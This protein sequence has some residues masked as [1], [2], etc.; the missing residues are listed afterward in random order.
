MKKLGSIFNK[1][2]KDAGF[3]LALDIGTEFVKSL[4]F[5][6]DEENQKGIVVGVGKA[7]QKIGNMTSGAVSDI[8]GVIQTCSDSIEK[9]KEQA[10]IDEVSDCIIGIAGEFVKGTTTTVH[11]ERAKPQVRIDMPELKN[12]VQKIQWKALER[13]RN[14]LS[15][16][17]GHSDID[18][19]LINAAVVGI[20]IDGY[21]VTKPIGFQGREVSIAIFNAYAPMIHLGAIETIA[22]ELGLKLLSIAAE[23]Y[24]VVQG[25]GLEEDPDFGGIFIDI[26][27]GTT[28]IAVVKNGGLEGTSMFALGGRAFTKRLCSEYGLSFNKAEELKLMYSKGELEEDEAQEVHKVLKNDCKVWLSGVEI[29]LENFCY[30]KLDV[31][32]SRVLLCGGG[33]GLPDVYEQLNSDYWL[34]RLPFAKKPKI[35]FVQPRDMVHIIDQT[36]SLTNPQDVTPIGLATLALE[37]NDKDNIMSD[38]LKRA[39]KII[40]N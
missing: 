33:S 32:P 37:I 4:V 25:M 15:F 26:G 16:E 28:D 10:G 24:A 3:I 39:V 21:K 34:E 5:K 36:K 14:Q 6:V 31:L 20:K 17:T 27:G 22:K 13:I 35:G 12:I 7:K 18:V 40:Q 9:A 38:V 30:S 19:K 2:K 1:S 11:Y 23:P 29:A 8:N